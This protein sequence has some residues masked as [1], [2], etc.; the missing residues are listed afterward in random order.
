MGK[1]HIVFVDDDG[2]YAGKWIEALEQLFDVKHFVDAGS[3]V[4]YINDNPGIRAV[5]LDVMMPTPQTVDQSE[6]DDGMSTGLWV[7]RNI[8]RHMIA[9]QTPV[10]I[11]T[12]RKV[13]EINASVSKYKFPD[14]LVTVHAKYETT[15]DDLRRLVQLK[16]SRWYKPGDSAN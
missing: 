11:H 1:Q 14:G 7:L 3:A 10:I 4:K 9:R 13:D 12:L 5:I 15:R 8:G 16:I 2:F 6:T